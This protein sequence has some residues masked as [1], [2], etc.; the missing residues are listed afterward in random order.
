MTEATM[1]KTIELRIQRQDSENSAP[2][3]DEFSVAWS[4]NMNVIAC[5]MEIQLNPVNKAGKKV[6]PI[7]W[8]SNCLEEVCG[9]CSMVINGKPRQACTALTDRLTQPISIKPLSKFKVVRDLVVD[10]SPMFAALSKV[11]AWMPLDGTYDLGPGPKISSEQ[12]E[13]IYTFARC[14]TCGCCMEA[15]PQYNADSDFIGPAPLGQANLFSQ[16]GSG[17]LNK[18]ERLQTVMGK[19]GV[20]DC[21]KSQNCSKACPKDIPLTEAIA[22]LSMETTKQMVKDLLAKGTP[23]NFGGPA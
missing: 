16:H 18:S 10:R 12:A 13:R 20:A 23:R 14:M 11:K 9:A 3:W 4:E 1:S 17:A 2:Y 7:V 21:G 15:C 5:L 22:E 19:G 8:E 6:D